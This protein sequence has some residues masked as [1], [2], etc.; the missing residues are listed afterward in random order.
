MATDVG[1]R[2]RLVFLPRERKSELRKIWHLKHLSIASSNDGFWIKGIGQKEN[3]LIEAR[4]LIDSTQY[5]VV[6]GFLF[7][8]GNKVPDK[9]EV[10]GLLWSDI[11]SLVRLE[12]PSFNENLFEVNGQ[13]DAELVPVSDVQ[14]VAASIMNV[15]DLSLFVNRNPSYMF[16]SCDWCLIEDNQGVVFG[17]RIFSIVS[18]RF[19]QFDSLLVPT[20]FDFSSELTKRIY[21]DTLKQTDDAYFIFDRSGSYL[22]IPKD[23][24]VPLTRSSFKQTQTI[25]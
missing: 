18:N 13:I 12:L 15:D 9:R 11:Q 22:T 4:K 5:E 14:E 8:P 20:G 23:K 3:D 1:N 16:D 24:L 25:K 6:D 2:L 19:W 10:K 7:L 21:N 17:D